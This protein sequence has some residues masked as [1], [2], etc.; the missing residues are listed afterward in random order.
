VTQRGFL[1]YP[2]ISRGESALCKGATAHR[3]VPLSAMLIALAVLPARAIA[4]TYTWQPASGD[5]SIA[6]NWGGT[7]PTVNDTAFIANSGT[8]NITLSGETCNTLILGSGTGSG[9]IVMTAGGLSAAADEFVGYSGAG[10]FAQSGGVNS[11]SDTLYLGYNSGA[12]GSYD[13]SGGS[14][15]SAGVCVGYSGTGSFCQTGGTAILSLG[16]RSAVYIGYD[17][18]SNGQYSQS[19]GSLFASSLSV[20]ESG[21]GMFGQSGGT[22]TIENYLVIGD[23]ANGSGSYSLSGGSLSAVFE[24]VPGFGSGYLAQS[25]GTNSAFN[26]FLGSSGG[27]NGSYALSGGSLITY[28]ITQVGSSSVF[29]DSG[30]TY[31]ATVTSIGVGSGIAAFNLSSTGLMSGGSESVGIAGNAVFTQ[32][33]GTNSAIVLSV[34]QS[35]YSGTYIL[36]GGLLLVGS[37]GLTSGGGSAAFNFGGG[38][39][40]ATA[41]WSSSLPMTLTGSGGNATV[42]TSGGNIGLAGVLS[43]T[44]GLT[45]VGPNTLT[46]SGNNSYSG[47]TTVGGGTLQLGSASALSNSSAP[48]NVAAGVLNIHGFNLNFGALSGGGTIDNLAAS[49]CSLTVGDGGASSTFGGRIQD[50]SGQLSLSK[51]GTGTLILNGFTNISGTTTVDGGTLGM[52]SGSMTASSQV[53]GNSGSGAFIQ[54]GGTTTLGSLFLGYNAGSSGSYVLGGTGAIGSAES[55]NSMVIGCSGS[56]VFLQSGGTNTTYNLQLGVYYAGSSG[57]YI[58]S[59]SGLLLNYPSDTSGE[60][61][62]YNGSGSFTQTGGTN[63]WL[64]TEVLLGSGTVSG[65]YVQS[66]GLAIGGA[67]VIG[68]HAGPAAASYSLCGGGQLDVVNEYVGGFYTMGTGSFTQAGGANT[69][70]NGGTLTLGQFSGSYGFYS[71]TGGSLTAPTL[72]VGDSGSAAFTQSGGTNAGGANAN[73]YLGYISGGSGAYNLSGGSLSFANQYVGYSGSGSFT[74]SGGTNMAISNGDSLVVGVQN[75]SSGSYM[76]SG[77]LLAATELSLAEFSAS[78]TFNQSGGTSSMQYLDGGGRGTSVC[79]LSGGSMLVTAVAYVSDHGTGVFNQ[80]GSTASFGSLEMTNLASA[81]GT[82]N[83]NGGLLAIGGVILGQGTGQFNFG[84]GTLGAITA[85]SSSLAMTLTGSGGNATIDTTGGSV[86]LTGPLSG[87]GG[88]TKIGVGTLTLAGASN[89]SGATTVL[90]GA[91]SAGTM[92]AFSP[93][94]AVTVAGGTLD[95]SAFGQSVPSLTMGSLGSL[96]LGIGNPLVVNGQANLAGTLNVLG[97]TSGSVDLANY[98]SYSGSFSTANVPGGYKL[99]YTPSQLDLDAIS[100]GAPTWQFAT[101]G[102][103]SDASKWSTSS[104]PNGAGQIAVIGAATTASW[105]ITLANPQTLGALTFTNSASAAAGYVLVAGAS[106]S[107]IMDNSGSPAQINVVSGSHSINANVQLNDNLSISVS[108]GSTVAIGGNITQNV[109]GASLTINGDG[110]GSILLSGSNSYSGTTLIA[111]G[112]L[113]LG[114]TAALAGST[115]DSSGA[116]TLRFG[117]SITTNSPAVIGGLQGPGSLALENTVSAAASV[118]VGGNNQA[119]TYSGNLSGPGGL[120]KIG[121]NALTLSGINTFTGNLTVDGGTLAMPGGTMTPANEFVGYF[122]TGCF[123]QSGGTHTVSGQ[124]LLGLATS[125]SGTYNLSGGQLTAAAETLGNS[126]TGSFMQSGGIHIVNSYLDLGG[127]GNGVYNLNGSGLLTVQSEEAVGV[128]GSGSFA[129]S[130]GTNSTNSLILGDEGGT[131]TYSLGGSG[132]LTTLVDVVGNSTAF[133]GTVGKF[134]Q[135]GGTHNIASEL[136]LGDSV[137]GTYNLSNSGVLTVPF[138]YLGIAGGTASFMQSGGTQSVTNTLEVGNFAG[139]GVYNLSGGL[140]LVGSGG[141]TQGSGTAAFN[142]GGGTL[143]ATAAWSSSVV[144]TLTGSGGNATIDTTGGNI[145]LSGDLSGPGGLMKADAGTLTLSGSNTYFGGTTVS[146]GSL[147]VANAEGLADGANLTVGNAAA[148]GTAVASSAGAGAAS[149]QPAPVPEPATLVL[150]AAAGAVRL[151]THCKRRRQ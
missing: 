36:N 99:S 69:I 121:S 12:N 134:I 128:T 76:L 142:F 39:L 92:N 59:G 97:S 130:G 73:L 51:L 10:S 150:L 21:S 7:L 6:S 3:Y 26:L 140:F 14:L 38:T 94:S 95:A 46:L 126:G 147:V 123:T 64:S 82:Y 120:M 89:Y 17:P 137:A 129:Q 86:T 11:I 25:A 29:T 80:T 115:F 149:S 30:G 103:W 40:G 44:A 102:N 109:A 48:V 112:T 139:D 85:W 70:S 96:N 22:S 87:S 53:V 68:Y 31:T 33:G 78:G 106:G 65:S 2:D 27:G 93:N 100:S 148:F 49:S 119:T 136:M 146:D 24:V 114:N 98:T 104:V 83:L 60:Q 16:F 32:S 108:N 116:G 151:A 81:S 79:N 47:G 145:S 124:L 84:G 90:A 55:Y 45:K 67:L 43:G 111:A 18:G 5:W 61:I 62:G 75:G 133:P 15:A 50:T 107:L 135:S 141:I 23:A 13:L 122:H 58:L 63:S 1:N 144:M 37:A 57:G 28:N 127:G 41:A 118:T 42:D 35:G 88:M 138:E 132:L 66:G 131:G 19:S 54:T 143:G 52:P 125:S 72:I 4:A 34:G 105:T 74:Q 8:A 113:S 71:L 110:T 56:G 9:T 117:P 20:G 77:G 91:L 101:S